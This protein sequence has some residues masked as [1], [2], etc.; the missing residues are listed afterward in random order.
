MEPVEVINAV[1]C[2]LE[3]MSYAMRGGDGDNR[4]EDALRLLSKS[5]EDIYPKSLKG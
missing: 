4:L 1:S 3:M 5:L 2:I